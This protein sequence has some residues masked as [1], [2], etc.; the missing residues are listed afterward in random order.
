[1]GKMNP[2]DRL[3]TVGA[4]RLV[5]AKQQWDRVFKAHEST[6]PVYLSESS[7]WYNQAIQGSTFEERSRIA[8]TI[9]WIY[10][11]IKLIAN[12]FSAAPL[13]VKRLDE[14]RREIIVEHPF[15]KVLAHP[16][17]EMDLPFLLQYLAY[18]IELRGKAYWFLAP[19][20]NNPN[21]IK[22]IW[23][24]RADRIWPIIGKTKFV[25][26]Y[27]YR[28]NSGTTIKI[29]PRYVVFFRTPNPFD[30]WD[31]LS[32]LSAWL[33]VQTEQGEAQWQKDTYTTGRG[34]PHSVI[35][36]DKN[37][38]EVDFIVAAARIREDFEHERKIAI[39]RSSDLDVK[40][41]GITPKDLELIKSRE[42]TRDEIDTIFLG[43]PIRD[44]SS[45][46]WLEAADKVVREK[47]I[48]PLHVLIAGQLSVQV[49]QSFYGDEE[50]CEFDDIRPQDRA[51]NVQEANIYWRVHTVDEAREKLGMPKFR[52]DLRFKGEFAD[53]EFKEY[54]SL[55]VP[56][57][58]DPSFVTLLYDIGRISPEEI[59]LP[60]GADNLDRLLNRVN[61]VGANRQLEAN[62]PTPQ[63]G[64]TEGESPVHINNRIATQGTA[65]QAARKT[66][67]KRWRKVAIKA[68]EDGRNPSERPFV[69]DVF[70]EST[71]LQING[72]LEECETTGDIKDLFSRMLNEVI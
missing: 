60:G 39:T 67:L 9:S 38:S 6:L 15:T 24:I 10:A 49:L 1:M 33:P 47:T 58:I 63:P 45:D 14:K 23:P 20:E 72:L 41:V 4:D 37:L 68:M 31:G 66:D 16:N 5:Y 53:T 36:L 70:D 40:Q 61:Q 13:Q 19:E 57:A 3:V 56:L 64:V 22:E 59:N 7:D 65:A 51:L 25:E 50:Y 48:W 46:V 28:L 35:A 54:G 44:H 8:L 32:P 26:K 43:V 42:F 62:K 52:N 29:D 69:T 12:E 34:I 71:T 11:D 55:P 30:L 27:V 18:W 2:I 21:V 17:S